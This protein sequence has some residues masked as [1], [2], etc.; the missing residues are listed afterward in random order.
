MSILKS[1]RTGRCAVKV[2]L[3]YLRKH[4]WYYK[5]NENGEYDTSKIWKDDEHYLQVIDFNLLQGVFQMILFHEERDIWVYSIFVAFLD[6]LDDVEQ[7][8][9]ERDIDFEKAEKDFLAKYPEAKSYNAHKDVE[10]KL[11][12]SICTEINSRILDR[13]KIVDEYIKFNK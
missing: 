3:D 8:W 1:T 7:F 2:D 12:Q 11:Q 4:G 5:K 13:F 10:N 6:H 9:K